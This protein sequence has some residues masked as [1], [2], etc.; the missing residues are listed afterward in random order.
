MQGRV[1]GVRVPGPTPAGGVAQRGSSVVAEKALNSAYWR[2]AREV[3]Q[4]SNAREPCT[5]VWLL[6]SVWLMDHI[7]NWQTGDR[8]KLIVN[9]F[10]PL[11]GG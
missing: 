3:P 4:T 7:A 8:A 6:K 9:D 10:D 2:A 1:R 5:F 11:V